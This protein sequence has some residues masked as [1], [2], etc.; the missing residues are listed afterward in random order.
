MLLA[1]PLP[2]WA[3][4]PGAPEPPAL[5]SVVVTAS[6]R[7]QRILDV[8][9][10][11]SILSAQQLEKWHA[12]SLQDIAG[13]V[14][15]LIVNS[16][17]SPGQSSIVLRGLN[18]LGTGT[19]VATAIDDVGVGSTAAQVSEDSFQLDL[20]PFDIARIEVLRGPQGTLYGA[21][22]MG[23]V[24]KYVTR[25]PSLTDGEAQ[26]GTETFAVRHGGNPGFGGRAAAAAP[27]LRGILALRV[28]GYAENTPGFIANSLLA[29][30]H[31]NAV[32]QRGG[33]IAVLWQPAERV[34]VKLQGIVQQTVA[35]GNA[36]AYAGAIATKN[37]AQ[38]PGDF[39]GG[40]LTYPHAVPESFDGEVKLLSSTMDWHRESMD[41]TALSA[42]VEKTQSIARDDSLAYGYL[43]PTVDPGVVSTNNR[44]RAQWR[45]RRFMQECRLASGTGVRLEWLAG[46]YYSHESNTSDQNQDALDRQLRLIPS[47]TPFEAIHGPSSYREAALFGDLT[48]R[49]NEVFDVTTGLRTETRRQLVQIINEPSVLIPLSGALTRRTDEVNTTYTL[50]SRWRWNANA[51]VYARM[52]SG[53]RPGSPN[54]ATALYPV[55]PPQSRAD[56]LVDYEVGLKSAS[57]DGR[58]SFSLAAFMLR[59]KNLQTTASTADGF[60]AYTI[61]AGTATSQGF[62]AAVDYQPQ[63]TLRFGANAAYTDA[64][65]TQSVPSAGILDRAQL[66]TSP[67]WT[68]AA[69]GDYTLGP[70]AGWTP[71]VGASWRYLGAEFTGVSSGPL[72]GIVPGYSLVDAR[73]ELL[74]G[75]Y[76]WSLFAKNLLDQ[77]GFASAGLGTNPGTQGLIFF[78]ALLQPR[79]LGIGFNLSL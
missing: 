48:Y 71:T 51:M 60:V 55:I 37:A 42:F 54:L 32:A 8:G 20:M 63:D 69:N 36:F 28:S 39:I 26:F 7:E 58:W 53:Y 24:L 74:R 17:G 3:A 50:G 65:A 61:N 22:S 1:T 47:L 43:Q 76:Q 21:N 10:S 9:S 38:L 34:S 66:P 59:W 73:I 12:T 5:D 2:D 52:A 11:I 16:G 29:N 77:R 44:L 40:D 56:E 45:S 30:P 31:E 6:K 79:I 49:F 35:D 18:S 62:E 4:D 27:L 67:R 64:H 33:R 57:S 78:G 70:L 41:F 68:A 19:L 72:V 15:G 25:Y 75:R 14:P 23:G 13:R 46:A